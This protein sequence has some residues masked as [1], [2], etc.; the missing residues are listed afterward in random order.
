MLQLSLRASIL[1]S[2]SGDTAS[3][4]RICNTSNKFELSVQTAC[5]EHTPRGGKVVLAFAQKGIELK[6]FIQQNNS[7]SYQLTEVAAPFL[8]MIRTGAA[9][10]RS[11]S[12]PLP[13]C[14]P[15]TCRSNGI[16]TPHTYG[17]LSI[18][19]LGVEFFN[20]LF[21]SALSNPSNYIYS[22]PALLPAS[23][24]K[25]AEWMLFFSSQ[26]VQIRYTQ[27]N[28]MIAGISLVPCI[29][30]KPSFLGFC[31]VLSTLEYFH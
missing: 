27:I 30:F 29:N 2:D 16:R 9:L 25:N 1:L 26:I 6:C 21:I 10:P 31:I 14:L 12:I 11:W 20:L 8:S 5:S 23:D 13:M 3:E 22:T 24:R 19:N 28:I 18:R 7:I 17:D 4:W 15:N